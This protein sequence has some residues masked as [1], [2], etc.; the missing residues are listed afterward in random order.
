[1]PVA[2]WN[3]PDQARYSKA[4]FADYPGVWRHG[5]WIEITEHQGVI[6]YGRSDATL[7]PGG[8]RIGTAEI[9]RPVESMDEILESLVVGLPKDDDVEV[10]LFVV[11][12]PAVALDEA[13]VQ[14]L[15][16][17]IRSLASPRH[18]PARIFAAPAVPRTISGKK[19]ELAV[20]RV[21]QGKDAPNR[22]ALKNP[23]VL[24]WFAAFAQDPAFTG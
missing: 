17:R 10:V 6:V 20:A 11:P 22:D 1:M 2:F 18:V 16:R 7:N 19:V 15:R 23:E 4:Y 3:D 5:D 13:L 8:V 14:T 9:Y 21:L 24:D 12:R